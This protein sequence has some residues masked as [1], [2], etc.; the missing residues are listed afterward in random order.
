MHCPRTEAELPQWKARTNHLRYGAAYKNNKIHIM[1]ILYIWRDALNQLHRSSSLQDS[2]TKFSQFMLLYE[3][4]YLHT[5]YFNSIALKYKLSHNIKRKVWQTDT[6]VRSA[7]YTT[8]WTHHL[9]CSWNIFI[10]VPLDIMTLWTITA[11]VHTNLKSHRNYEA[12]T[13]QYRPSWELVTCKSDIQR[14]VH[15]DVFL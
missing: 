5:P 15:H 3:N 9:N 2:I 13:V 4:S 11:A 14:T 7:C 6:A 12:N 8:F 10:S 1:V